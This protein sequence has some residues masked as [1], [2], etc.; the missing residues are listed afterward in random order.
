MGKDYPKNRWWFGVV[1]RDPTG[2][3]WNLTSL[4]DMF[5]MELRVRLEE[6]FVAQPSDGEDRMVGWFNMT[7]P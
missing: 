6:R 7:Q 4:R 1:K 3:K 5:E 2:A